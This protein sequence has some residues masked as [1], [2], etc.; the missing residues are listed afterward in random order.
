LIE[1]RFSDSLLKNKETGIKT[2][3]FDSISTGYKKPTQYMPESFWLHHLA[4]SSLDRFSSFLVKHPPRLR[5]APHHDQAIPRLPFV[6]DSPHVVPPS[7]H[8]LH[9]VQCQAEARYQHIRQQP[10]CENPN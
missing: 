8:L 7:K 5:M 3:P 9:K 4:A 10:S 6:M 2:V 1:I